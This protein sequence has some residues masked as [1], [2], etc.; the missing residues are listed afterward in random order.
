MDNEELQEQPDS[1][2]LNFQ[3]PDFSFT[4]KGNHIWRQSGYYLICKSCE[5]EHALYVGAQKILVGISADGSPKLKTRQ[6]L[7]MA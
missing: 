2:I 4:P 5:L 1:E 3:Q 6:E 7:G